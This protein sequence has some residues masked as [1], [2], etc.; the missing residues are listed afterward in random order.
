MARTKFKYDLKETY[1]RLISSVGT[2]CEDYW[3]GDLRSVHTKL[4]DE[5]VDID[6]LTIQGLQ[7]AVNN[8]YKSAENS[9]GRIQ[10]KGF[11]ILYAQDQLFVSRQ[12][13][14]L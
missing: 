6:A 10:Q 14:Q 3:D 7:N 5:N 12:F 1:T 9:N 8:A 13:Q 4:M 11:Y 2:T